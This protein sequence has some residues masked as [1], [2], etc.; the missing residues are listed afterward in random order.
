MRN[1]AIYR[2]QYNDGVTVGSVGES[3]TDSKEA[4]FRFHHEITMDSI[5]AVSLL[6]SRPEEKKPSI[7]S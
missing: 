3:Q 7:C 4:G 6:F 2:L 1:E 5:A